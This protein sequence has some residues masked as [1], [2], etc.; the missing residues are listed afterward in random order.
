MS[1]DNKTPTSYKRWFFAKKWKIPGTGLRALAPSTSRERVG[2]CS[3]QV[4]GAVRFPHKCVLVALHSQASCAPH[5]FGRKQNNQC[6]ITLADLKKCKIPGTGLLSPERSTISTD[7]LN[8]RVRDG[9]G[10][11]PVVW[12]T[13]NFALLGLLA[14]NTRRAYK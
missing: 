14:S 11:G 4:P 3:L 1:T 12:G 7:R 8:F 2:T 6:E 13:G 9:N 10:C 5:L